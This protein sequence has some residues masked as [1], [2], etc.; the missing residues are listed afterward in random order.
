MSDVPILDL[1]S[2]LSNTKLQ[3]TPRVLPFLDFSV[4]L[5]R[6]NLGQETM[7]YIDATQVDPLPRSARAGIGFNVGFRYLKNDVEWRPL[8]F[9]W[10]REAG[11]ILAKPNRGTRYQ[12]GFGDI[13]F[14]DEIVLGNTNRET[15]KKK[16]WELS[17]CDFLSI[18]GGR[19]EEDP[20]MGNR[21][22]NTSGWGLR[23]AGFT[24]ILRRVIAI[25]GLVGFIVNHLDVRYNHSELKTDGANA[26]LSGTKF[27]SFNVYIMN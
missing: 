7:S 10:T 8:T 2:T 5:S 13:R 3:L 18:R 11:T 6:N 15:E 4:G 19:F 21:H 16:G 24:K 1:A 9:K 20:T 25:E 14:F 12:S 17:F 23:L 26:V 27:D 22:F